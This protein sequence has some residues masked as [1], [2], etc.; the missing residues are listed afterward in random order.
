MVSILWKSIT[1]LTAF[2]RMRKK[3]PNRVEKTNPWS[4]EVDKPVLPLDELLAK[5]NASSEIRR[6]CF[7]CEKEGCLLGKCKEPL[8]TKRIA[9]NLERFKKEKAA[10]SGNNKWALKRVN[11]VELRPHHSEWADVY[12]TIVSEQVISQFNDAHCRAEQA[13]STDFIGMN[14]GERKDGGIYQHYAQ[15]F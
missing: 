1:D 3:G 15:A 11:L 7:N 14:Q 10:R 8:N 9:E 5:V 2:D 6:A 4:D 13:C 12:E